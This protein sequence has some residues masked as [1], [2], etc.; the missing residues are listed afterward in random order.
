MS[1]KLKALTDKIYQE[2]IAKAKEESEK[3]LAQAKEEAQKLIQNAKAEKEKLLKQANTDAQTHKKKI[4]AEIKLAAQKAT[5]SVKQ[6]LA[7]LLTE[8]VISSPIKNSLKDPKTVA[9]LLITCLNS[10]N[11]NHEGNWQINLPEK[12]VQEIKNIIA[13]D[14]QA[15]LNG[16]VTINPSNTLSKGFEVKPEGDNYQIKFDDETFINFFGSF[17]KVETK[18]IIVD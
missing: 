10:L 9:A 3:I 14:K 16:G 7:K 13:A 12:D 17:L 5:N 15:L 11:K 8:K 4:D 2:G 18:E 6:E 1:E